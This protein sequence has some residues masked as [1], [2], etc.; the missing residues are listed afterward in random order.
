MLARE[1]QGVELGERA[2]RQLGAQA[3]GAVEAG[4]RAALGVR[5]QHAEAALTQLGGGVVEVAAYS[6]EWG[7]HQ[8]PA[9]ARGALRDQ[10]EL[11][12]AHA[13]DQL[14]AKL[15]SAVQ[16]ELDARVRERAAQLDD[17][18]V[19]LDRVGEPEVGAR[20]RGDHDRARALGDGRAGELEAGLHVGGTVVHAG[21]QV[22]VKV[23]V[24]HHRSGSATRRGIR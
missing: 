13:A 1:R 10:L 19:N 20:V 23:G 3:G 15:R 12:L 6:L 2:G 5:D 4:V 16:L 9:R 11:A 18:G 7:L 21:E 8:H 17:A 14:V 24:C 22:E